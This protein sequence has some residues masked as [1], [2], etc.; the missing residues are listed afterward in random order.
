MPVPAIANDLSRQFV[1][2]LDARQPGL[3]IGLYL[4]G[5]IALDDF[6]PDQSDVDFLAVTSRPVSAEE[7]EP[8]HA[9]LRRRRPHFDGLY[10][11]ATELG[12]LPGPD[13]RGVAVVEG[14][15]HPGSGA[16]RH[17]VTWLTLAL[18]GIAIRGKAPAA[19]W[20]AGDI[21][22]AKA[23]ARGNLNSYWR[24]WIERHRTP[25]LNTA[26]AA[27]SVLGISRLHALIAAD[28]LLSKTSAGQYAR[29]TFPTHRPV[30]DAALA[31][32][33]GSEA[34]SAGYPLHQHAAIFAF[35]DEI[36]AD[37]K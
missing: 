12:E 28:A 13:A 5:S 32:R 34:V 20:I 6:R 16:E 14:V 25:P 15:V 26:A 8:V 33:A 10:V 35:L 4:V 27:W 22:A 29:E 30:I 19:D 11:T 23:H 31:I 7:V 3:L 2:A 17:A 21:E 36:L 24:P 9:E 18:H 1:A 37:T